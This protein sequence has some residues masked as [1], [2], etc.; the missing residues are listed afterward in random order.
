MLPPFFPTD[1]HLRA[2]EVQSCERYS[3]AVTVSFRHHLPETLSLPKSYRCVFS[4]ASFCHAAP[5]CIP[6]MLP[7]RLSSSGNF[8][9]VPHI[10]TSS[11]HS[12]SYDWIID[13]HKRDVKR[14][15]GKVRNQPPVC[16]GYRQSPVL[17]IRFCPAA[18]SH[19]VKKRSGH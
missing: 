2:H 16:S 7:T 10:R 14:E 19:S 5:R 12:F 17:R 18:R 3:P 11:L 8:L 1:S 4:C 6:H 13:N 15:F 9:C